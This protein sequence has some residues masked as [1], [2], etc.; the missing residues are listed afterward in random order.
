MEQDE[1]FKGRRLQAEAVKGRRLMVWHVSEGV[2]DKRG[3]Y[4]GI[5]REGS[6]NIE[7]SGGPYLSMAGAMADG[8]MRAEQMR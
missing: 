8:S 4:W 6:L 5:T 3:W 1:L 2:L 7:E